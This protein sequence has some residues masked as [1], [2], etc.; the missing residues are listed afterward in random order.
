MQ[1]LAGTS[2]I[3]H[4]SQNTRF[5]DPSASTFREAVFWVYVR[6]CLYNAVIR[7]QPLDI[8]FSLQLRP[9]PCSIQHLHHLAWLSLE[10]AWSNQILWN[11]AYV[12]N[13]CFSGTGTQSESTPRLR[14]WQ[15]LWEI[16]QIWH[17]SRPKSFDPIW[18]GP[19][20]DGSVFP[21]IWFTADCHGKPKQSNFCSL[22]LL[23]KQR[24]RLCSIT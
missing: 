15:E 2:S 14:Q 6:Q 21:D 12:A 7:Q 4:A 17:N 9:A 23:N 1:H 22:Y 18:W 19:S 3:L 5:V 8:D 13:F 16:I 20:T 10:T 11:T 24:S